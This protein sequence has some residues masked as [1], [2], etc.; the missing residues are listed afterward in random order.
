MSDGGLTLQQFLSAL[1][2]ARKEGESDLLDP[3]R[4]HDRL[5]L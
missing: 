3:D 5:L 1:R 4:P 2:T